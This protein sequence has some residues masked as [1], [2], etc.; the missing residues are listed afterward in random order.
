MCV[1]LMIR[2]QG[3]ARA[4]ESGNTKELKATEHATVVCSH[5]W[6]CAQVA[7]QRLRDFQ[8]GLHKMLKWSQSPF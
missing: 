3:V 2:E 1:Q 7:K 5:E 6:S 4:E 8:C